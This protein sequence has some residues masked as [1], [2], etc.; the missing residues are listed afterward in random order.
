MGRSISILIPAGLFVLTLAFGVWLGRAGKPYGGALLNVHK[1]A[2][3]AAVVVTAVLTYQVL[4]GSPGPTNAI[5]LLVF[6]GVC[7]LALFATGALLSATSIDRTILSVVHG[8]LTVLALIA[9]G[10]AFYLLLGRNP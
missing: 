10:I 7:F 4:R 1:L 5:A 8:I 3:L 9:A 2:A 6:A